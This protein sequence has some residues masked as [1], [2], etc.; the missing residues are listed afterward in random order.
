MSKRRQRCHTPNVNPPHLPTSYSMQSISL[1]SFNLHACL[2]PFDHVRPVQ[3]HGRT[4]NTN[5]CALVSSL[6][7]WPVLRSM[8]SCTEPF[9]T[10]NEPLLPLLLPII[11]QHLGTF[12]A[13]QHHWLTPKHQRNIHNGSVTSPSSAISIIGA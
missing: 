2:M 5:P 1:T 13:S 7:Q 12:S 4:G 9:I 11:R 10:L 8:V 3:R 6:S